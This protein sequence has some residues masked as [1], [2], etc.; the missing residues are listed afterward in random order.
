MGIF[1]QGCVHNRIDFD[2]KTQT[3]ITKFRSFL[4]EAAELVVSYGGSLSGEHGDGQARAELLPKMFGEELVQAFR[5]FKS[6]WDP[7]G[8]MNPGK[9]VDPYR[10]DENLRLGMSYQPLQTIT[11]FKFPEDAG[12]MAHATLRCVGVGTCRRENG[13]KMCP[14][15]MVTRE[16]KHSTRGRSRLL[17]EMFQGTVITGGWRDHHVKDAMDL[18]LACK[19]CKSECPVKV[20]MASYKAEFLSHYYKNRLRP[21]AAYTMGLIPWWSRIAAPLPRVTNFLTQTPFLSRLAKATAGIAPERT[22]PAFATQ[23][24][25][26]WFFKRASRME[27]GREVIL[28]P[29]TFTNH[30]RPEIARAALDVLEAIGYCVRIPQQFL[31]CGRPLYD[32]GML[33]LAKRLLRQILETLNPRSKEACQLSDWNR[34]A[35]PSFAMSWLTSFQTMRTP[36][37]SVTKHSC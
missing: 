21:R 30:F 19:A 7:D 28:W 13:G 23:T 5:E 17:F 2:L 31:C 3:G 32:W 36:S 20:D 11:S 14:S 29:D 4:E 16:E 8:K 25:K 18:C 1:G 6:I 15:Y 33:D 9:I 37:D 22:I 12:S 24:F 34:V 35:S 26:D 27:N 10:I